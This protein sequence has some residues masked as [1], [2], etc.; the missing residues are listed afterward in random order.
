MD[1]HEADS[2]DE[3]E[4][5]ELEE[6]LIMTSAHLQVTSQ[7]LVAYGYYYQD[8]NA[9]YHCAFGYPSQSVTIVGTLYM[10][11]NSY[12]DGKLEVAGEEYHTLWE[13]RDWTK[14][15]GNPHLIC[16]TPD[17]DSMKF[18]PQYNDWVSLAPIYIWPRIY[19]RELLKAIK[20]HG[21][22]DYVSYFGSG[23]QLNDNSFYASVT[24][25]TD[26][27]LAE[28]TV[29]NFTPM[30]P[31]WA[32]GTI[33]TNRLFPS[34]IY[35]EKNLQQP[36][37]QAVGGSR[38]YLVISG[39]VRYVCQQDIDDSFTQLHN[40][41]SSVFPI[42][43]KDAK[44][45]KCSANMCY[46]N[47]LLK[48]ADKWWNGNAWTTTQVPFRV[49]FEYKADY[50]NQDLSITSNKNWAINA[51]GDGF[52]IKL[53]EA[54]VTTDVYFAIYEPHAIG[55]NQCSSVVIRDLDFSLVQSG[56]QVGQELDDSD[57]E[58]INII[59][60]S[61]A[62]DGF[63]EEF[64]ICT[65]DN[66]QPNYSAVYQST[67]GSTFKYIDKLKST[68]SDENMRSEEHYIYK[69]VKQYSEPSIALNLNLHNE[70]LP[71]S[72]ATDAILEG[73]TLIVDSQQIDYRANKSTVRLIEKK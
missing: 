6:A 59:D 71:W 30:I 15:E 7:E 13:I 3:V 14:W 37:Q 27:Q 72:I 31:S 9:R 1:C 64:K 34:R 67:D 60:D 21:I 40:N 17:D 18:W 63:E 52:F 55:Y 32:W 46:L 41:G 53:P 68:V 47:C 2:I 5:V 61:F 56:G 36:S 16:E 20:N 66:K 35:V 10:W 62:V 25:M 49:P 23:V 8:Q 11:P 54:T 39:K 58:Y 44:F 42:E 51:E 4:D 24:T 45:G 73:K 50:I 22:T 26:A 48:V 33:D 29:Y 19:V 43:F 28:K 12:P 65:W 57:T 38:Q 69:V 70:Y